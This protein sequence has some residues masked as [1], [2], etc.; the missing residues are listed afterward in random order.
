MHSNLS[1]APILEPV[2]INS[3]PLAQET[4]AKANVFKDFN[5]SEFEDNS[6]T[7]FELVELQTL[8]DIDELKSVLQPESL[9]NGPNKKKTSVEG[10]KPDA[11]I[12]FSI[13]DT[14]VVT[15]KE[16]SSTKNRQVATASLLHGI[17]PDAIAAPYP[18]TATCY[19]STATSYSSAVSSRFSSDLPTSVMSSEMPLES[20][21]NLLTSKASTA[22]NSPRSFMPSSYSV[23]HTSPNSSG[24]YGPA[25]FSTG[26]MTAYASAQF[27]P[28]STSITGVRNIN[29]PSSTPVID[30]SRNVNGR[31]NTPGMDSHGFDSRP[32]GNF[33]NYGRSVPE[34]QGFSPVYD[35]E[36]LNNFRSSTNLNKSNSKSLPNLAESALPTAVQ[37]TSSPPF[38]TP[39]P[40]VSRSRID[41]IMK[42]FQFN[43]MREFDG[44]A[45]QNEPQ[46]ISQASNV[47][48][49]V[50]P[51]ARPLSRHGALP[52]LPSSTSLTSNTALPTQ[53][54]PFPSHNSPFLTQNSPF[55]SNDHDERSLSDGE[56][57]SSF[58][59]TEV[60]LIFSELK[61]RMA[62]STFLCKG[63][64]WI[65][66]EMLYVLV[67][68]VTTIPGVTREV[69]IWLGPAM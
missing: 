28:Q 5:F 39:E 9:K 15:S 52:P 50:I 25:A 68:N 6:A 56:N 31:T 29:S 57:G 32:H 10:R 41:N 33:N 24:R 18:F 64:A 60:C 7:P 63:K 42:Q 51:E 37:S 53:K 48:D 69:Q 16:N 58:G 8:D 2:R 14:P 27:G 49:S 13:F 38:G 43:R 35:V 59:R 40:V 34:A 36:G 47:L 55:P 4:K 3:D 26:N 44:N 21:F 20:R 1:E 45:A 67:T 30:S 62:W 17:E 61:S 12:D 66:S 19:S 46:S 65:T 54:S 23:A 22:Q 11:D